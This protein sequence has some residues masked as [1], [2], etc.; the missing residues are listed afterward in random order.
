MPFSLSREPVQKKVGNF[1]LNAAQKKSP[2]KRQ[3]MKEDQAK[4]DKLFR[5]DCRQVI[6]DFLEVLDKFAAIGRVVV[7]TM[8]GSRDCL[9]G[10]L[11]GTWG[12]CH[13]V[14]RD[15]FSIDQVRYRLTKIDRCIIV[16]TV[17]QNNDRF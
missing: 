13:G 8:T 10:C 6:G 11:G 15:V 5:E 4:V 3:G 7:S 2:A 14:Y 12:K 17:R 9:H 16:L 1:V